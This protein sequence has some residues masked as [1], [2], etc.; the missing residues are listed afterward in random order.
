MI[1]SI[2]D[3]PALV[4][5]NVVVYA[6]DLDDPV[7]HVVAKDLLRSLSDSGH[8]HFSVQVFNEFASVMISGK[9]RSPRKPD[10]VRE[11]LVE[12]AATGRILPLDWSITERAL[13]AVTRHGLS[14]WDALV[15]AVARE[16]GIP[17]LYTEDFQ[18]GRDVDGVRF[19]NPFAAAG[20][21]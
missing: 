10:E 15:W 2:G 20:S 11:I 3:G 17:V 5:T 21:P 19:L 9:K 7:K 13:D 1:V 16:H 8:L 14:F 6:Y 12:L 4:D 18:H